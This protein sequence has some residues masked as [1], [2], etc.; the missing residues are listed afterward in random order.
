VHWLHRSLLIYSENLYETPTAT[1]EEGGRSKKKKMS[2]FL[3]VVV[4]IALY[5]AL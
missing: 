3:H 4:V 1:G 2:C 5:C